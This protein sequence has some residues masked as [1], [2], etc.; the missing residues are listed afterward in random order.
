MRTLTPSVPLIDP[1]VERAW[2]RGSRLASLTPSVPL[3]RPTL[4]STPGRGGGGMGSHS[5][6]PSEPPPN[7]S[8]GREERAGRERGRG[9]GPRPDRAL[10]VGVDRYF[11][12]EGARDHSL[13]GAVADVLALHCYLVE[14]LG[15]PEERIDTLLSPWDE[16]VPAEKRPSYVNVHTALARLIDGASPGEQ[17]LFFWSGHGAPQGTDY[18]E[19]KGECGLDACLVPWDVEAPEGLYLRDVELYWYVTEAVNRGLHPIVFLDACF[20]PSLALRRGMKERRF[21]GPA[22]PPAG[23]PSPAAPR[24]ALVERWRKVRRWRDFEVLGLAIPPGAV[25]LAAGTR[26]QAAYEAVWHGGPVRG[27]FTLSLL[28]ELPAA[29]GETWQALADRVATRVEALVPRQSPQAEGDVARL[30]FEQRRGSLARGPRVAEVEPGSGRVWVAAGAAHGLERSDRL[31]LRPR[32]PGGRGPAVEL[33]IDQVH[34]TG[35]WTFPLEPLPP[36]GLAGERAE[37]VALAQPLRVRLLPPLEPEEPWLRASRLGGCGLFALVGGEEP[38]PFTLV[39]DPGGRVVIGDC[40]GAPL[41]HTGAPLE[42][43]ERSTAELTRRLSHLARFH[44]LWH[45]AGPEP[46]RALGSEVRVSIRHRLEEPWSGAPGDPQGPPLLAVQTGDPVGLEVDGGGETLQAVV[47]GLT[48]R[49]A[50]QQVLPQSG[51]RSVISVR[52]EPVRRQLRLKG[53]SDHFPGPE[54]LLILLVQASLS[55]PD[56]RWLELPALDPLRREVLEVAE[57]HAQRMAR[58]GPDET[59]RWGLVRVPVEVRR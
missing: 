1:D 56:F 27:A 19:I 46:A 55:P 54:L 25:L 40:E 42:R 45:L 44:R 8:P 32:L 39:V 23:R 18:P 57:P 21:T 33:C 12:P 16:S 31:R 41:P 35:C 47:L 49:W 53:D 34:P 38:A 3:S 51:A 29:R 50:V 9:E 24:E 10:L 30:V 7:P 11:T 59:Q 13:E 17:V 2:G 26:E 36:G 58:R 20:A 5:A 48:R 6:P 28:A 15:V 43:H 4:A 37:L 14:E 22:R 52:R